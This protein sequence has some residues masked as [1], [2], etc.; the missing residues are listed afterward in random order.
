MRIKRIGHHQIFSTVQFRFCRIIGDPVL[1][2]AVF[3]GCLLQYLLVQKIIGSREGI[4]STVITPGSRVREVIGASV[5]NRKIL[6]IYAVL[7][8]QEVR[9]LIIRI[10]FPVALKGNIPCRNQNAVFRVAVIDT[11]YPVIL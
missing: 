1:H 5:F 4:A 9:N 6:Q 10:V 7:Q 8:L 3:V 2:L 11:C